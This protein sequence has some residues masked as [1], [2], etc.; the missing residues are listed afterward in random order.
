MRQGLLVAGKYRLLR[1]LGQGGMGAV[2]VARHELTDREFAIKFLH[3]NALQQPKVVARFLQEARVSGR[4]RHP[5]ILEIFDVGTATE[6]GNV[7]F[8]VMEL[9]EG[10]PLDAVIRN[11]RGVPLRF[12]LLVVRELARAVGIANEKGVVHRDIKPA[13]VFLHRSPVGGILP[14][15]LD[16]GISKLAPNDGSTLDAGI[17]LTQTGAVLGSPLYMSP[18]QASG[19][20]DVDGRSDVHALGVLLYEALAGRSPFASTTYNTLIVEIIMH[21][22]PR[23]DAHVAGVPQGVGDLVAKAVERDRELRWQT[24]GALADAVDAQLAALGPGPTL[25]AREWEPLLGRGESPSAAPP[26]AVTESTTTSAVAVPASSAPV[27]SA[28]GA[29]AT[30][31]GVSS[32]PTSMHGGF[33]GGFDAGARRRRIVAW[34]VAAVG[35]L[36]AAGGVIVLSHKR[37]DGSQAATHSGSAAVLADPPPS[38]VPPPAPVSLAPPASSPAASATPSATPPAPLS[39]GGRP[40][41][42]PIPGRPRPAVSA[43]PAPQDPHRGVTSSGL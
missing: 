31:S 20:R 14:K 9:L 30:P 40:G 38:A 2:W 35:V 25:D 7:P 5:S 10:A 27:R 13:N 36:A 6:M 24:A 26:K 19:R 43:S 15:L 12:A 37:T 42:V 41:P 39:G 3:P 22:R 8:L 34:S 17:G 18:E 23:V 4:L 1:H 11:H 33:D 32:G 21:E 28:P 16:F 29:F